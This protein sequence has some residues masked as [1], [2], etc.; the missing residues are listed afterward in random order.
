MR[1]YR[2]RS[3]PPLQ[4]DHVRRVRQAGH[5]RRVRQAGHVRRVR[6]ADHVRRVRQAGNWNIMVFHTPP[7]S[8]NSFANSTTAKRQLKG[9]AT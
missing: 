6:Q 4:A 1:D 7:S 5:V 9:I 8:K 3:T 2:I